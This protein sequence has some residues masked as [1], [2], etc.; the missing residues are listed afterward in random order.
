[1]AIFV[2]LVGIP[3]EPSIRITQRF[4]RS[5]DDSFKKNESGYF[6][7]RALKTVPRNAPKAKDGAMGDK[8][9]Y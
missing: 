1:M 6:F 5:L 7:S 3:G 8:S 9:E 4:L 2:F